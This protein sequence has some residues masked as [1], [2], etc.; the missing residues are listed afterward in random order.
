MRDLTGVQLFAFGER[1]RRAPSDLPNDRA[2][3]FPND[4]LPQL[5]MGQME[6][7]QEIVVKE[8]A[9]WAVPDIVYQRCDPKQ[10]FDI[11]LRGNV[12]EDLC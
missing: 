11:V 3:V 4:D 2:E 5:F 9:K 12:S 10:R 7:L 6:G 8:M 1:P